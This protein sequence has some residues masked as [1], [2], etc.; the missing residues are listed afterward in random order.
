MPHC[1]TPQLYN[2]LKHLSDSFKFV[3]LRQKRRI[4]QGTARGGFGVQE[5]HARKGKSGI[6]KIYLPGRFAT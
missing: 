5:Y 1:N 2:F 3:T 6:C 4:P